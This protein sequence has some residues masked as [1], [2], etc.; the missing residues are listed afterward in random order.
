MAERFFVSGR[1]S[2]PGTFWAKVKKA[3]A[4]VLPQPPL[5]IFSK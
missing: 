2:V 3:G 1:N 5:D 4:V